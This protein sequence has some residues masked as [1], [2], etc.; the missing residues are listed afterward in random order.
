MAYKQYQKCSC[1]TF[2]CITLNSK[3]VIGELSVAGWFDLAEKFKDVEF[4]G[5][6]WNDDTDIPNFK[7]VSIADVKALPELQKYKK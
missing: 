6:C 4:L 2:T 7:R 1:E 3:L 5:W